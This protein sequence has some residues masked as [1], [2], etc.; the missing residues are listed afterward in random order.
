MRRA[1]RRAFFRGAVAALLALAA[2]AFSKEM[3]VRAFFLA[4]V[5]PILTVIDHPIEERQRA[6]PAVLAVAG[7]ALSG[8][9]FLQGVYAAGL[10]ETRSLE[11]GLQA[12][13]RLRTARVDSVSELI[14]GAGCL[15]L[16]HAAA[17]LIA[18]TSRRW[19]LGVYS[20]VTVGSVAV[21]ALVASFA[22]S[23]LTIR[24]LAA[25]IVLAIPTTVAMTA[26]LVVV[27]LIADD[28]EQRFWPPAIPG[29]SSH[30]GP[31]SRP[32]P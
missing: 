7:V 19:R 27:I 32:L 6:R 2:L 24:V 30:R 11:G 25:L 22:H 31:S 20:I 1:L 23:S 29:E 3:A 17:I 26:P 28:F 14:L 5:G 16:A 18:D 12:L 8:L 21:A 9:A 10:L 15:G 13:D 4:L